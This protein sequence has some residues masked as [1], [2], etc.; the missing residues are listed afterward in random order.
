MSRTLT[1]ATWNLNR[2][3][4]TPN[5]RTQAMHAQIAAVQAD[6]W[7]LTETHANLI[8]PGYQSLAT[9]NVGHKSQGLTTAMLWVRED[10][11]METIDVFPDLPEHEE[12]MRTWP[13]FTVSS[14]DTAPAVC[15][16]IKTPTGNIMVYGTV[17]TYFGDR[18]PWGTSPFNHEQLQATQA[19]HCDWH[20]LRKAYGELPFIVAGDFNATCDERNYPS[21]QIC[22]ALRTAITANRLHCLTSKHWID[23]IC[24]SC[25]HYESS[26]VHVCNPRYVSPRSNTSAPISDHHCVVATIT[27]T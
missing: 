9:P 18:G 14:R 19:H 15:A 3:A 17:M 1:I 12:P 8:L 5:V 26:E 13:S 4:A 24:I 25:E 2:P 20:R 6:I 23:H 21:K 16:I 7:V 27:L 10:W 22:T 11:G